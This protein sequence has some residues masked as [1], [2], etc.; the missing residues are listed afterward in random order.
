MGR[1]TG[2]EHEATRSDGEL[3][4]TQ[5]ETRLSLGDVER[6]IGVR[7]NVIRGSGFARWEDADDGDV[8]PPVSPGPK[9]VGSALSDRPITMGQFTL[10]MLANIT[11]ES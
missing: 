4:I 1:A 7:V 11:R 10:S 8:G 9:Y 3:A 6:L 5:Q 2:N